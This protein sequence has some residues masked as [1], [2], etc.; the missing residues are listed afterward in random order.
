MEVILFHF[1]WICERSLFNCLSTNGFFC[2][3]NGGGTIKFDK[4]YHSISGRVSRWKAAFKANNE[5]YWKEISWNRISDRQTTKCSPVEE[6]THEN[7]ENVRTFSEE[8][9]KT[10][11]VRASLQ[12]QIPRRSLQRIMKDVG[13]KMYRPRLLHTLNDDDFDRRVEFCETLLNRLEND[14]TLMDR[15]AWTDEVTFKLNGHVN[16]AIYLP[17]SM[18]REPF[19][20]VAYSDHTFLM[21]LWQVRNALTCWKAL[22]Y[23]KLTRKWC[24]DARRCS[25]HFS[26]DVREYLNQNFGTWIGK[27]GLVDWPPRSPDLTPCDYAVWGIM[28]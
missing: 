27:R 16:M 7:K 9:P 2:W 18:F 14:E 13:L 26:I 28:K 10:S 3:S 15:V 11:Q 24:M 23:A 20:V 25:T 1:N 6:R 21:A 22:L 19:V 17:V 5:C 12:L 8:N 4:H